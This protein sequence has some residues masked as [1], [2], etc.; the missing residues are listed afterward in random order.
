[1][2]GLQSPNVAFFCGFLHRL[3]RCVSK[4]ASIFA[5]ATERKCT[6]F[7]ALIHLT[8]L[9][10]SAPLSQLRKSTNLIDATDLTG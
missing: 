1:M 2:S 6:I 5:A 7:S 4:C 8:M 9:S 3:V 10:C